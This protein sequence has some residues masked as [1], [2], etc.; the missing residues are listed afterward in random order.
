MLKIG[1]ILDLFRK[2]QKKKNTEK[3][4]IRFSSIIDWLYKI[5]SE[6]SDS[7][8][9]SSENI[10]DS[11]SQSIDGL[12]QN[13]DKIKNL[14]L[15]RLDISRYLKESVNRRINYIVE[16]TDKFLKND[17]K[18]FIKKYYKNGELD[19]SVSLNDIRE[20]IRK[21]RKKAENLSDNIET[22]IKKVEDYFPEEINKF[23][24]SLENIKDESY[25]SENMIFGKQDF[26]LKSIISMIDD[27]K[28]SILKKTKIESEINSIQKKLEDV[29]NHY[30][31]LSFK[32][33]DLKKS[34]RYKQV[35]KEDSG[36]SS[37]QE[38]KS[39][40]MDKMMAEIKENEIEFYKLAENEGESNYAKE[41]SKDFENTLNQDE[42]KK[43]KEIL[44]KAK[45][46]TL[47]DF[48]D[49]IE[50]LIEEYDS[51]KRQEN[52]IKKKLG[53]H[54]I[55]N[56]INDLESRINYYKDKIKELE[57]MKDEKKKDIESLNIENKKKKMVKE[58]LMLTGYELNVIY[59]DE[60]SYTGNIQNT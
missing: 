44:K 10:L 41:L 38:K 50:K 15:E 5:T 13:Y 14:E 16:E 48:K 6:N 36:L 19:K 42:G 52:K 2:N 3:V 17:S 49:K 51:Q 53:K 58:I 33:N 45:E 31:K 1:K 29:K 60:E 56:E 47:K 11:L 23:S 26:K 39:Q 28:T 21:I 32:M 4:D 12:S 7:V 46:G 25:K 55:F 37:V 54:A 8:L 9:S 24:K 18:Y 43:L 40:I 35:L 57:S 34:T 30:K 59:D 20:D 27:I 22:S